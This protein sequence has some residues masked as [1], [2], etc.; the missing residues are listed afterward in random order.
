[1]HFQHLA[2]RVAL[3]ALVLAVLTAA[4]A[5]L[6]VR[7]GLFGF[8]VGQAVM[9][10]AAVLGVAALIC[11]LA[12]LKSAIGRND[13]TAKR[14]GLVALVGA[15]LFLYPLASYGWYGVMGLP[16]HDATSDPE[17]PPQFV[18]LAKLRTAA[19]N[20]VA[21][22]GQRKV[23]WDGEDVPIAYA[24][25]EYKNGLITKPHSQLMPNNK[26]PQATL[27]WRCFKIVNGLGW[28]IVDYS[29]KEGR[30]EATAA[31]P[32]FGQISD[33]VVRVRPSGYLGARYDVRAQSRMGEK[34]HG[35]NIGLVRAFK[36]RADS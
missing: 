6:G 26:N 27:F 11:A 25:H 18:A 36:D 28:H 21:F 32:W 30:I 19:Q 23:R 2:A 24:L 10:P 9:I 4:G 12:W 14:S 3:A 29:E 20:P 13:G 22:D 16:I 15:L 31:S 5:I 1:M 17:D 35:F 34:D 8:A 33:V 7:L